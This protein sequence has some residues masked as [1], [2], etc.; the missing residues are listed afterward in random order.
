M[1]IRPLLPEERSLY[2]SVV[3]HPLQSW[4]WGEF[5]EKTG[6]K[7]IRM[8]R[9][10][11]RQ[12]A[13]AWQLTVHPLPN[14]PLIKDLTLLYCPR[15]PLPDAPVLDSL[16]QSAQENHSVFVRLEPDV[17]SP[18]DP[19]TPQTTATAP[20]SQFLTNQ[21]CRPAPSLLTPYTFWVNLSQSEDQLMANMKEK[22][23]YNVRLAQ[24]KG[25]Q[26]SEDNS[27]ASFNAY[28]ELTAQTTQRQGFYAHDARYHQLMWN[29]LHPA[30]I[31]HLLTARYQNLILAA[32]IL[33]KFKDRLYYPYGASSRTHRDVMA[34]NLLMWEAIRWGKS[35]G[36]KIFDLWGTPGPNPKPTDPWYGFH[37]FKE[38][39]GPQLVKY[40]GTFD[41]VVDNLLYPF[42]KKAD[43][44]RRIYLRLKSGLAPQSIRF[45]G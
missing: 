45:M 5:R 34:S 42:V 13:S 26:V 30:G 37:H 9:F 7:V 40:I 31:A 10:D 22:T 25:V 24:K 19:N 20:I 27:P 14:L 6:I 17:G 12:L 44:V 18:I 15:G 3:T 32:W 8:G 4:E 38:G 33:F 29:T 2:N 23:R 39:Y 36:C 11:D 28:L 21:G 43:Q 35:Q 16:T 41:L 1:L